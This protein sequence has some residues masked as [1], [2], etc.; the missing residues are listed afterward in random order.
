M[1]VYVLHSSSWCIQLLLLCLRD[2]MPMFSGWNGG[3]LWG[4]SRRFSGPKWNGLIFR[5]P[6]TQYNFCRPN[7][8]VQRQYICAV[9]VPAYGYPHWAFRKFQT[10]TLFHV[11]N[12][13]KDS[14]LF[15]KWII[16]LINKPQSK[17]YY[18]LTKENTLVANICSRI[19]RST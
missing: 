2:A 17:N 7:V 19:S 12:M 13:R 3:L 11:M 1:Y 8:A 16:E 5:A 9:V 10:V 4:L 6:T 15:L 18:I 14:C